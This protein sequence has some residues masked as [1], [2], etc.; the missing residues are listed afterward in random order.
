MHICENNLRGT[1]LERERLRS[2]FN[3][4]YMFIEKEA[5]R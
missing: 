4:L 5:E 1:R 2:V 3:V